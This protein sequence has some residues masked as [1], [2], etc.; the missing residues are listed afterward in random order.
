[1]GGGAKSFEPAIFPLPGQMH[2]FWLYALGVREEK[3]FEEV[4]LLVIS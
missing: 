1:M 4:S 3:Q 2:G